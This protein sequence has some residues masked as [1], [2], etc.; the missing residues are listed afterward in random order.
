[1]V[2]T[3]VP[4]KAQLFRSAIF[5]SRLCKLRTEKHSEN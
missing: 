5:R 1:M 2:L 4:L 3:M